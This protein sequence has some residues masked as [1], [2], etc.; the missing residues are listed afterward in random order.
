MRPRLLE[1]VFGMSAAVENIGKTRSLTLSG[2]VGRERPRPEMVTLD[3]DLLRS[4]EFRVP[5][6]SYQM[7]DIRPKRSGI[8]ST[9]FRGV[10]ISLREPVSKTLDALWT[11]G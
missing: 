7:I 6:E 5:E 4:E 9:Q 11:C 2:G 1:A 10:C 3:T 8:I